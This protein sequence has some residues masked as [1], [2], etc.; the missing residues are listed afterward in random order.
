[1]AILIRCPAA[2]QTEVP[3]P[4]FGEDSWE[5]ETFTRSSLPELEFST[6]NAKAILDVLGEDA[7]LGYGEI[8]PDRFPQLRETL[9]RHITA[10]EE[11][12]RSSLNSEPR[13]FQATLEGA[14]GVPQTAEDRTRANTTM[15]TVYAGG[16]STEYLRR[17]LPEL[18]DLINQA[19]AGGYTI[20]WQ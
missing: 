20:V 13:V 19:E 14:L 8:T 7:N 12:R 17:R 10:L 9:Q 5:P 11:G 2:P 18:L 15:G 3:N 1:M 6:A 16:R 4:H